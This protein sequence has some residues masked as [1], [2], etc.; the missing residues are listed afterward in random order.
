MKQLATFIS[1]ILISTCALA[2]APL[3]THKATPAVKALSSTW[4]NQQG[5]HASHENQGIT[6]VYGGED[7]SRQP[8]L[9]AKTTSA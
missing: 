3:S 1:L 7:V 2:Q 9:T 8:M 6:M 4:K 5:M